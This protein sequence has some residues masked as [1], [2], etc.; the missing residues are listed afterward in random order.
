MNKNDL[1]YLISGAAFTV[2]AALGPGL[3]ESVY[4][5]VLCNELKIKGLDM[6]NQFGI[7]FVC[8]QTRFEIG[9]E[10]IIS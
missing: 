9:L 1:S 10:L 8:A 2:H 3:L 7:S 4:E 5:A 6:K